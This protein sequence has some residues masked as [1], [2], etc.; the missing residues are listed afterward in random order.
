MAKYTT[1]T[2]GY[3][4]GAP[5]IEEFIK[6]EIGTKKES[7]AI[8]HKERI[9]TKMMLKGK[10][11]AERTA[12][13]MKRK[14]EDMYKAAAEKAKFEHHKQNK[15][16]QVYAKSL[17]ELLRSNETIGKDTLE[18][19]IDKN[20]TAQKT[21]FFDASFL[22]W[23]SEAGAKAMKKFTD[24][25]L[26]ND[27]KKLQYGKKCFKQTNIPIKLQDLLDAPTPEPN[28]AYKDDIKDLATKMKA[29][30]EKL[31]KTESLL[32]SNSSEFKAMKTAIK[33]VNQGLAKGIDA[34]ELGSRLE[35]L[36]A[37][38][39]NYVKAKGVG[40]QV[41]QRGID[42]MDAALDICS[43]ASD[44]MDCFTSEKRR[45]EVRD[46]EEK[47]FGK[48]LSTDFT[49]K[50]IEPVVEVYKEEEMEL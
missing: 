46:F 39:M 3:Y 24:L 4:Q 21:E 50:H 22:K 5:Q 31:S 49:D 45:A 33:A 6:K 8:I 44:N 43:L 40:M 28:I 2:Q 11:E 23:N 25:V 48:I 10:R 14:L 7:E 1:A 37:A 27:Q 47:H 35:T 38:S 13:A 26:K 16:F 41:T 12:P 34:S 42:R 30:E 15:I 32:H 17:Y 18:E 29:L 19:L 36:Q 20:R 9:A